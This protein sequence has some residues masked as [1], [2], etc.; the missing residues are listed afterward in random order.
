MI[1]FASHSYV[2]KK[3]LS[4]FYM[5]KPQRN[6]LS[7]QFP[8]LRNI[9]YISKTIKSFK[10]WI[11]LH[12]CSIVGSWITSNTHERFHMSVPICNAI[13]HFHRFRT[14][15]SL[16]WLHVHPVIFFPQLTLL[17]LI[18]PDF[19]KIPLAPLTLAL[20]TWNR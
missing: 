8:N 15:S 13:H 16:G 19:S 4:L 10:H 20:L 14:S 11:G 6:I 3:Y 9:W 7:I 12:T 18:M 5:G 17:V 2:S 1:K